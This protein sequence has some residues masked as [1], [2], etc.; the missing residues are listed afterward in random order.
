MVTEK[1]KCI[2]RILVIFIL[3][4]LLS[5]LSALFLDFAIDNLSVVLRLV[6]ILFSLYL[7]ILLSWQEK[8][9]PLGLWNFS[10]KL[11]WKIVGVAVLLGCMLY[12]IGNIF[13]EL[14]HKPVVHQ[15][16]EFSVFIM[17]LFS[18]VFLAA[19][20]EE[21]FCRKFVITS[22]E[23]SEFSPVVIALFSSF[24]FY[25]GHVDFL[26]SDYHQIET[27]IMGV[28]LYFF[29]TKTREVRYCMIVHATGNLLAVIHQLWIV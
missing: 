29:Y 25:L 20:A 9:R 19:F 22:M 6:G 24:L 8:M 14:F 18:S 13:C 23:S 28:I 26:A 4:Y 12:G 7:L 21:L 15:D 3:S 27:F 11:S 2:L 17:R 16:Y 1:R 10:G 5:F